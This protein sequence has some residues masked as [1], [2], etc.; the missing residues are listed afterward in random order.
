MK[1]AMGMQKQITA[2]RG[3]IDALQSKI[4][5]LEEAMAN[6]NEVSLCPWNG[7]SQYVHSL[8]NCNTEEDVAEIQSTME[9]RQEFIPDREN[10]EKVPEGTFEQDLERASNF[11]FFC[12]Y[13]GMNFILFYY[14][15]PWSSFI[16]FLH[17]SIHFF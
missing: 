14:F 16:I 7:G 10:E 6:A 5:F 9:E 13:S 8:V 4:Q 12:N 2:K 3:Q 15:F 11:F 1:V 17:V